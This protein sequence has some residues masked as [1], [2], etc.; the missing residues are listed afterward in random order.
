MI[1]DMQ[2]LLKKRGVD[3]FRIFTEAYYYRLHS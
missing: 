3:D 1:F 2:V